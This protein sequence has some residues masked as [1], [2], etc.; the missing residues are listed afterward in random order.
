[1]STPLT[2][3]IGGMDLTYE[4]MN[5]VNDH[6]MLFQERDR[7]RRRSNSIDYEYCAQHPEIDVAQ[8]ELCFCRPLRS[9]VTRLELLG[10]TLA[11]VR[12]EYEWVVVQDAE[13]RAELDPSVSDEPTADGKVVAKAPGPLGFDE[14]MSFVHAHSVAELNDDF[15]EHYDE[16][17]R[18]ALS[19]L[20][21]DPAVPR[22]PEGDEWRD[23]GGFSERSHLGNLLGFLHPYSVLRVLAENPANLDLD[24]VWDYGA[25]VDAG[26]AKNEYFVPGARR[27]DTYLIATEGTSDTHILKRAIVLLRPD[28]E[29]FFRF[30]DLEERHPFSGTGNLAKFAEGL[31]KIDVHNRVIFLFDNDA[32]GCDT[33]RSLQ[34]YTFPLNMRAMVLP[35]LE[36]FRNFPARGPDG[37]KNSD[38][39]GRAA[40][41]ECYLDLR[42]KSRGPARVTW[43]NFKAELDVYQGSLDFKDS[44]AKKFYKTSVEEV[45]L[46]AYDVS[47]LRVV[48]GS[49]LEECS[50]MAGNMRGGVPRVE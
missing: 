47:K 10:H 39:N 38:I 23:R 8:R 14:F 17:L 48:L 5:M 46:G 24:V 30:I 37:V 26:W 7:K 44:Y 29:D 27:T 18:E 3:A 25:F 19:G 9:M 28:V 15:V 45:A 49:L 12:A 20:A 50:T 11:T 36:E 31:V 1:M 42:L 4:T 40:S 6:G 13:R 43:T 16:K 21:T 33:R 35:D 22:M 32:E 2:L 34:K 41:I